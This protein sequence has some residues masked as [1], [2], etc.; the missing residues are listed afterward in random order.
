MKLVDDLILAA[1]SL[2]CA[3]AAL[4]ALRALGYLS[5]LSVIEMVATVVVT[6]LLL[7]PLALMV[8]RK[9]LLKY[10][11]PRSYVGGRWSFAATNV[12]GGRTIY[13]FFDVKH[14]VRGG[15]ITEGSCWDARFRDIG[16]F[17]RLAGTFTENPN[18]GDL[19]LVWWMIKFRNAKLPNE[20]VDLHEPYSGVATV[21]KRTAN[22]SPLILA[23]EYRHQGKQND[24]GQIVFARTNSGSEED[25]PQE[26][27][28]LG[29]LH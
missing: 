13:G 7:Y 27:R 26:I 18:L 12:S 28:E 3:A 15:E 4:V 10:I 22:G 19:R 29:S 23:G 6:G 2:A 17:G 9:F 24:G 21:H 8:H 1:L 5:V 16:T 11:R 20:E 14:T 25:L